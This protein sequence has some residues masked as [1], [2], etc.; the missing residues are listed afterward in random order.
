MKRLALGLVAA[1]AASLALPAAAEQYDY[2][3]ST[4]SSA[5]APYTTSMSVTG[6]I[7]TSG[8]L[9]PNLDKA[10]ITGQ[11][12]S[13]TFSDGVNTI[14]NA[15]GVVDTGFNILISGIVSTDGT[16]NITE[17]QFLARTTP[18]ATA[19]SETEDQILIA[20]GSGAPILGVLDAGF[21]DSVCTA[22]NL[23]GD[24]NAFPPVATSASTT[25]AGAWTL[26]V[27]PPPV[28]PGEAQEIPAL[29]GFGLFGAILGLLL[30]GL[31]RLRR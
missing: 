23:G 30:V 25:S 4:F 27:E 7:I 2:V 10:D 28:D 19:I 31:R 26:F 6:Q 9:A 16:G 15:N 12:S 17:W 8:P 18:L 14:S 24:C 1:L 13:F 20:N 5:G 29:G 3:G 21:D 22:L 11:I